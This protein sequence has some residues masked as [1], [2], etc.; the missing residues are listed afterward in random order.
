MGGGGADAN[1]GEVIA[2]IL[3]CAGEVAED[4]EA[5]VVVCLYRAVDPALAQQIRLK[6]WG[7]SDLSVG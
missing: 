5:D 4:T 6:Q 2:G 3:E 7:S 1:R